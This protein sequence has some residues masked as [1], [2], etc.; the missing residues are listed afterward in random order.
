MTAL[1]QLKHQE[2]KKRLVSPLGV[3]PARN[4]KSLICPAFHNTHAVPKTQF[5]ELSN[6]AAA[7]VWV[8]V[9]VVPL[10]VVVSA[11]VVKTVAT[12]IDTQD[13]RR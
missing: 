4:F 10:G 8:L 5:R 12:I 6:R 2:Q 11:L 9:A 7:V 1:T 13:P 3:Q